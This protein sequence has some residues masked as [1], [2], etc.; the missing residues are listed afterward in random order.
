MFRDRQMQAHQRPAQLLLLPPSRRETEDRARE[1]VLFR[2]VR[3]HQADVLVQPPP[4]RQQGPCRLQWN[5]RY[6]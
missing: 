5:A 4:E 3:L 2:P 1:H 6:P